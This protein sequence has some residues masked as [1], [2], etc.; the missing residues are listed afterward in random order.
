[1]AGEQRRRL[2]E[3]F[4][5]FH[6][7]AVRRD[8]ERAREFEAV[9]QRQQIDV[10]SNA[11]NLNEQLTQRLESLTLRHEDEVATCERYYQDLKQYEH[12][13]NAWE[14]SCKEEAKPAKT[15]KPPTD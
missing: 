10:A 14:A 8:E 9:L 12:E 7:L 11:R 13:W 6:Q 3:G 2:E 4:Q 15:A 5:N 1:M